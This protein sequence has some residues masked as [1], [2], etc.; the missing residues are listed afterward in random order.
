MLYLTYIVLK[1]G[2]EY[3]FSQGKLATIEEF[4][5]MREN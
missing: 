1:E 3:E 2:I 4:Y 5:E